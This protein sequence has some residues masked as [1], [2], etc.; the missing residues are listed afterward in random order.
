MQTDF[1]F[2]VV[3]LTQT[4]GISACRSISFTEHNLKPLS[5]RGNYNG[6]EKIFSEWVVLTVFCSAVLHLQEAAHKL[7]AEDS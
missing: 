3:I 6:Q 1:F 4:I 7:H 5:V 2:L